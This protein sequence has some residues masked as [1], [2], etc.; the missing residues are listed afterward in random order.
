METSKEQSTSRVSIDCPACCSGN[1][2]RLGEAGREL[3]C[4][5]CG[6]VLAGA[7]E[8]SAAEC[9]QCLFCRGEY[10]YV[11]SPFSLSPLGKD[12]VCYVCEAKYRGALVN[13]PD[14]KFSAETQARARR[15]AASEGWRKRVELYNQ[16]AR[17]T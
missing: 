1:R 6:F 8:S 15:S 3:A 13:S 10:F 12:S 4:D 17:L 11:E 9:G 16:R 14:Q 7:S 2:F 5:D